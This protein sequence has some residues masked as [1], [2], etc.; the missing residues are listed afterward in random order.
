M[1]SCPKCN[2]TFE[3]SLDFCL[4]DGTRLVS[5]PAGSTPVTVEA[6]AVHTV[7][8]TVAYPIAPIHA[9][10]NDLSRAA[11]V[12]TVV[13]RKEILGADTVSRSNPAFEYAAI[14]VAL[15]HNWW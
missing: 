9:A 13:A 1:K 14:A 6:K 12:E 8:P 4:E 5:M 7:P 10:A 11:E 15:A 2:R 3:N